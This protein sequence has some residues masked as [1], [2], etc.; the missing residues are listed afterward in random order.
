MRGLVEALR[1]LGPFGVLILAVLDSAGIP[2]VGGVDALLI[3]VSITNRSAAYPAA[4]MAVVG[5]VIGS[6]V[7]LLIG[8]KGGHAY[9]AKYTASKRGARLKAWFLE[10]G[11]LTVFV[12][13]LVPIVPMPLKVF[14]LCAGA[15]EVSPVVFAGVMLA[16]RLL[17][18]FFVA[19]LGLQLGE[20]TL[21][22][23]R[24]H[25]WQLVGVAVGTFAVLYGLIS[26]L[27]RRRR[28]RKMVVEPE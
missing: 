25:I 24:H 21:P 12:P 7:M 18:Y 1:A 8:R 11:L 28:L 6:L 10:Y 26:V 5:S 27:D 2:I 22:Y 4:A 20:G 15:F 23:L 3:W 9:L 19:W 13:S 14:V 16:A 17:H